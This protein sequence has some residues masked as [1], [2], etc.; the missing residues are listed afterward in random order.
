MSTH[1]G[2]HVRRA[3]MALCCALV[4][5]LALATCGVE[6][7]ALALGAY[8]FRSDTAL[9]SAG[10]IVVTCDTAADYR[11]TLSPGAGQY[12]QRL[13]TNAGH[14]LA[15]NLYVDVN[16]TMVWGDG[17]GATVTASGHMDGTTTSSDLVIYGLIPA[18]QNPWP[19][20]Y[21]DAIVVTLT[22]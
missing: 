6:A 21:S 8:D 7:G 11:V 3:A 15:Y 5:R 20:T 4:P 18:R 9:S 12:T 17:T 2:R 1:R 16:H 22:F 10:R 19:G 13:L 14:T